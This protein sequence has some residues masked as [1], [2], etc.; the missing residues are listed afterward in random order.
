MSRQFVLLGDIGTEHHGFPPTPVIG[1]S[2]TVL[3]DNKPIGRIGDPLAPHDKPKNSTHGRTIA[4]GDPTILVDGKPV[5]LTGHR[6]S[7]G[8]VV[9]GSGT[10]VLK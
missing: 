9:I 10:A 5:A 2:T 3:L 7:C 1:G 6:V 8:G 4:E